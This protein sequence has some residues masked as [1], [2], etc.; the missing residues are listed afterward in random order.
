MTHVIQ[1]Y[2][3]CKAIE[4]NLEGVPQALCCTS[5]LIVSEEGLR[6][7]AWVG[8][9][10]SP[11]GR[12]EL[13][14]V[15]R[16]TPEGNA[17]FWMSLDG[18]SVE[19][20][21]TVVAVAPVAAEPAG[22]AAV[23][24]HL[25]HTQLSLEVISFTLADGTGLFT[26]RLTLRNTGA[27]PLALTGLDVWA[28]RVF[29]CQ[30]GGRYWGENSKYATAHGDYAVGHFIDNRHSN[31]GHFEWRPLTAEQPFELLETSGKSGWGH[32]LLYLRD[33]KAGNIFVVQLAW[34]GNWRIHADLADGCVRVGI[35]LAGPGTLR[36]LAP[37]EAVRTPEVHFG[38]LAGDLS[39][40]AQALH[41]HQRRSVLPAWDADR[42]GLVSYNHWS[43][44]NHEMSEER[45]I[46]EIDI[47]ADLGAEVFT[48]D[49]GW[50]G[51]LGEPWNLTGRWHPGTRLPNG[52]DPV[53]AHARRKGIKCGLWLWIEAA[54]EDSPIVREHPDWLLVVDGQRLNNHLDLSKPEVAA[55]VESEIERVIA[56]YGLDLLRLDY[57]LYPGKGG[58]HERLGVA[59]Q[60]LW[61]HYEAMYGIW[62]RVRQRHPALILENCAGGGGRTDLG[63]CSRMDFT[64]FSDFVLAPRTVRMQ[65]GMMLALPPER[66]ARF[67]GV[68]MNGHLGGDL[69]LQV[70]MNMLLG[71]PC[72]SGVWPTMEDKNPVVFARLRRGV[73]FF[74]QVFRP[75]MT[76]CRVYHHTEMPAGEAVADWQ[77][78]GWCVIEYAAPDASQSV[79]AA[80]RL[81]GAAEPEYRFKFRGLSRA[82]TYSVWVDNAE[83]TFN[84]TGR[85]LVEAGVVIRLGCPMTSELVFARCLQP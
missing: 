62:E 73:E 16:G 32:P 10:W 53:F 65:Q 56:E 67:T 83:E 30:F 22:A 40:M 74:K 51:N 64:W 23:E 61:R 29:P 25:R 85:E 46:R 39:E 71:N 9:Y 52:F 35:G 33:G 26:R 27:A 78:E 69:D 57:N 70:R 31:E 59:E 12:A 4:A 41:A 72:I 3:Q 48:I 6:D 80:F 66:L 75:L 17:A 28:G 82:A 34:S 13:D 15:S 44:M 55:W 58:T 45:L 36:V 54:S 7:G 68:V 47:A 43:Y 2:A 81:A 77:P 37:G 19:N 20:A 8:R 49:A 42:C 76:D 1:P 63:M 24:V 5:G 50:Y 79:G 60:T 11:I 21:W 18:K 14:P 38:G 84:A